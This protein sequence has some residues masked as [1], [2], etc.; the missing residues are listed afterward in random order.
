MSTN[1]HQFFPP[2]STCGPDELAG[3]SD[4]IGYVGSQQLNRTGLTLQGL[5]RRRWSRQLGTPQADQTLHHQ[6]PRGRS[7]MPTTQWLELS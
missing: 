3:S 5:D 4:T 1:F 6:M 2:E 7:R